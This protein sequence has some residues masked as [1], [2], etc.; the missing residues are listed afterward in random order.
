M[1]AALAHGPWAS[2]FPLA[3]AL[4]HA[5]PR[6][7]DQ[8]CNPIDY[9]QPIST[10]T[11]AHVLACMLH[12]LATVPVATAPN[13][14]TSLVSHC[15]AIEATNCKP[16]HTIQCLDICPLFLLTFKQ[17]AAAA[18][19]PG[20]QDQHALSRKA[21]HGTRSG[22]SNNL[23]TSVRICTEK[24]ADPFEFAD[25]RFVSLDPESVASFDINGHAFDHRLPPYFLGLDRHKPTP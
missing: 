16:P 9:I 23:S 7:G 19:Q 20:T 17:L 11:C 3:A 1:A 10:A 4:T 24:A 15:R 5:S 12:W 21:T 8:P 13:R 22:C 25:P 6:P 14:L 2:R 18:H